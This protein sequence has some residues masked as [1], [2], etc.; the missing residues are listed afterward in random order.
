MM[1]RIISFHDILQ[2]DDVIRRQSQSMESLQNNL[3]KSQSFIAELTS[4][5]RAL[6]S[7]Q[8]ITSQRLQQQANFYSSLDSRSAI[9]GSRSVLSSGPIPCASKKGT[10]PSLYSPTVTSLNMT[11]SPFHQQP[12][13]GHLLKNEHQ[14][15]NRD[16]D[17][18][19][20]L[21]NNLVLVCDDLPSRVGVLDTTQ[22]TTS[23]ESTDHKNQP[24]PICHPVD[25][26]LIAEERLR[27]LIQRP[28]R[29][30]DDR[31]IPQEDDR[32]KIWDQISSKDDKEM[33]RHNNMIINSVDHNNMIITYDNRRIDDVD[34]IVVKHNNEHNN[35]MIKE[36]II[37][38]RMMTDGIIHLDER[39]KTLLTM[40]IEWIFRMEN[41][42]KNQK[43]LIN[44][45]TECVEE[46]K[47]D[48]TSQQPADLSNIVGES[49]QNPSIQ[50][51][52]IQNPSKWDPN[53]VASHLYQFMKFNIF[54]NDVTRSLQQL[55]GKDMNHMTGI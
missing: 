10:Q 9:L 29:A 53:V 20:L 54:L 38:E 32:Y 5:L 43:N 2:F 23:E 42:Q 21:L 15:N 50:N 22:Q 19:A 48:K 31:I 8:L 28:M 16:R 37:V 46:K 40:M 45:K 3:T 44:Q 52:S 4:A 33:R 34:R 17:V 11:H 6:E 27:E 30:G 24:R 18:P 1:I 35:N 47:K 7:K 39:T 25:I 41:K 13:N 51:P 12:F 14:L 26:V 36:R 55:N 49:N